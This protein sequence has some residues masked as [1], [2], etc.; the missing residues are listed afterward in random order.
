[1]SIS[2]FHTPHQLKLIQELVLGVLWE[3]LN[4]IPELLCRRF[5]NSPVYSAEVHPALHAL[6]LSVSAKTQ[7]QVAGCIL[8]TVLCTVTVK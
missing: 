2:A 4:A 6:P 1:M 7:I 8:C 3:K 5:L